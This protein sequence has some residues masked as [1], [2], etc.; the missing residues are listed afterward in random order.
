MRAAAICNAA[1]VNGTNS[2]EVDIAPRW[3]AS[4]AG[5]VAGSTNRETR[6]M[7]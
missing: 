4:R 7:P 2:P 6:R 1:R 3:I 5:V